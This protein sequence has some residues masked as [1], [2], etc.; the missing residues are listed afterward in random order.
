MPRITLRTPP[1]LRAYYSILSAGLTILE[2]R[3]ELPETPPLAALPQ[4]KEHISEADLE[5]IDV[6][7]RR[8]KKPGRNSIVAAALVAATKAN[9]GPRSSPKQTI[10]AQAPR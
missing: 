3:D 7:V 6:L 1:E 9:I 4:T 2:C 5:R 10:T 8:F